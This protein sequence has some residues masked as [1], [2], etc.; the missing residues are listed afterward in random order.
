MS[1]DNGIRKVLS[2]ASLPEEV[3]RSHNFRPFDGLL[4]EFASALSKQMLDDAKIR[5][6][7]E[8]VA[9]AFWMRP[10]SITEMM[11]SYRS[12]Q[13]DAMIAPRGVVFHVAPAN[14]DTM[15]VYSWVVSMLCG[16]RNIIRISSRTSPQIEV[17]LKSINC[18]LAQPEF[19]TMRQG[20]AVVRYDHSEEITTELS[21]FADTRIIWGGD[22][23]VRIIRS[24][25]LKPTANE[26]AFPNKLSLSIIDRLFWERIDTDRRMDVAKAFTNDAFWFGQAACSSPRGLIWRGGYPE[27]ELREL[28]WDLV[29]ECLSSVPFEFDDIDFV[30]KQVASDLVACEIP[31]KIL[32]A[33]D[34]RVVR[35]VI[36]REY[37][38][39][40]LKSA[41]HCGAGQFLETAIRSLDEL[42]PALSRRIQTIAVAGVSADDFKK[43]FDEHSVA[44]IDR[45]VPFGTAL[46]FSPTWDGIELFEIFLRRI[47]TLK[48]GTRWQ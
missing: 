42:L 32:E 21:S 37:L 48:E 39:D 35:N 33:P 24:I 26:V 3:A 16:N 17:L 13:G 11:N 34:N 1:L 36:S 14:V 38:P 18:I 31:I 44:G 7:P 2:S 27:Q 9:L 5:I 4:V 28:F 29:R 20:I 45:I 41:L 6:F 22:E 15:F 40:A 19:Q 43:L 25:P 47:A 46:E 23:T 8:L 30:N 10:A 12:R